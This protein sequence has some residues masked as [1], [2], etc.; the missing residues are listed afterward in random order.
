MSCVELRWTKCGVMDGLAMKCTA[1]YWNGHAGG[2]RVDDWKFTITR[3]LRGWI[4]DLPT[5]K[6]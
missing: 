2:Q 6:A 4:T 5:I 3:F 1:H